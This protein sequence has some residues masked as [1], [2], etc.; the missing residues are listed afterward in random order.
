MPPGPPAGGGGGGGAP[1]PADPATPWADPADPG[2]WPASVCAPE[3]PVPVAAPDC[4]DPRPSAPRSMPAEEPLLPTLELTGLLL[5]TALEFRSCELELVVMLGVPLTFDIAAEPAPAGSTPASRPPR[6]DAAAM[7][8]AV[9]VGGGRIGSAPPGGRIVSPK[10]PS[11]G[12]RIGS[13]TPTFDPSL[14]ARLRAAPGG[15]IDPPRLREFEWLPSVS[16]SMPLPFEPLRP[17]PPR[18][19]RAR[20][21]S[22]P[23]S[24][25]GMSMGFGICPDTLCVIPSAPVLPAAE[26]STEPVRH[27]DG[28]DWKTDLRAESRLLASF[29]GCWPAKHALALCVFAHLRAT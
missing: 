11:P 27:R 9:A 8:P 13:P 10:A 26:G 2:S 4:P 28:P 16:F 20:W 29:A 15:P 21:P 23:A 6:R 5:P 18:A 14:F 3:M 22:M 7:S 25:I 1:W 19:P 17:R 12:G 24:D